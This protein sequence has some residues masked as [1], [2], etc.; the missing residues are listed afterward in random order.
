MP[1]LYTGDELGKIK[2]VKCIQQSE[3]WKLEE[4]AAYT[5]AVLTKFASG[6]TDAQGIRTQT[7]QR[8]T[9]VQLP[10]Q[11]VVSISLADYEQLYDL[12]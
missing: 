11:S 10:E 12:L 4:Q 3:G 9:S 8:L 7:V 2:L 1:H 6:E 5:P